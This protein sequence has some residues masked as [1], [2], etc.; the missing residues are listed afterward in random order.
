MHHDKPCLA[1]VKIICDVEVF[2]EWFQAE[3]YCVLL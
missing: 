3:A 2:Q 1:L